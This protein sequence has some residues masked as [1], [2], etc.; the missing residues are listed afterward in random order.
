MAR[1]GGQVRYSGN[2]FQNTGEDWT[3]VQLTLSTAK[4]SV[5]GE[6]PRLPSKLAQFSQPKAARGRSRRNVRG[7]LGGAAPP[8]PGAARAEGKLAELADMEMDLD[9]AAPMEEEALPEAAVQPAAAT[10]NA[11]AATFTVARKSS[12]A[13][14]GQ[15]HKVL[16]AALHLACSTRHFCVPSQ[17]TEAYLQA[18]TTNSSEVVLLPSKSCHVFFDGNF[19]TTTRLEMVLPGETFTC[20]L[21]FDAGVKVTYRPPDTVKA[22]QHGLFQG[23]ATVATFAHRTIVKNT[24]TRDIVC[25]LALPFP[26]PND[27]QIKVGCHARWA[28]RQIKGSRDGGERPGEGH[29]G[30]VGFAGSPD[31]KT[32]WRPRP[33][34]PPTVAG[35]AGC[36][37]GG[38]FLPSAAGRPSDAGAARSPVRWRLWVG[39][40][41]EVAD[42]RGPR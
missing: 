41:H 42:R 32:L 13:S 9:D 21:G 15:S 4:P 30:E 28:S 7:G 2:V 3:E 17:A 10:N 25:V 26:K 38:R 19:V 39:S 35:S 29:R 11:L 20:F 18:C 14:D 24:L 31:S 40:Q 23:R 36:T 16:L 22:R 34:P 6:P 12:I 5:G 37:A 8:A 1:L 27:N 33:L